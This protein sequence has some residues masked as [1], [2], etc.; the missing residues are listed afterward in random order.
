[1]KSSAPSAP[2][3]ATCHTRVHSVARHSSTRRWLEF[4]LSKNLTLNH[5]SKQTNDPSTISASDVA[6]EACFDLH[7]RDWFCDLTKILSWE[8][9]LH[10]NQP[11][12]CELFVIFP[13]S[14]R[15]RFHFLLFFFQLIIQRLTFEQSTIPKRVPP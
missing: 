7:K 10:K 13:S 8:L 2:F 6:Q 14:R 5:T 1:M 12:K 4:S 9:D 3:V 15:L 11:R